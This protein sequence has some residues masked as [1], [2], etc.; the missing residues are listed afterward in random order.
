VRIDAKS[1]LR[2]VLVEADTGRRIP[3]ARKADLDTGEWE[4]WAAT[5]DGKSVALPRRLL[6]GRCRLRFVASD[7]VVIPPKASDPRDLAGSLEEAR[8][9]YAKPILALPGRGCEEP[10]CHRLAEWETAHERLIEPEA[11]ADGHAYERAVTVEVHRWCS[12]HYRPPRVVNLRGIES[13]V[14]VTARPQ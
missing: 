6:R 5:P 14:Q 8:R 12:W 1:G 13:E 9:R 2:G 4:A 11:G 10:R 3:F 7:A